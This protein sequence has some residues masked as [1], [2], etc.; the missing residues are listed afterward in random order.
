MIHAFA[1]QLASSVPGDVSHRDRQNK[2]NF[3]ETLGDNDDLLHL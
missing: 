1:Q 2:P 3:M